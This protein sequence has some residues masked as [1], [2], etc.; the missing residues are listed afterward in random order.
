M[1]IRHHD[2]HYEVTILND[3]KT[4]WYS[5]W[6]D[7]WMIIRHHDTHNEVTVYSPLTKN[8]QYLKWQ[9]ALKVHK[10]MSFLRKFIPIENH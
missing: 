9:A 3:N 1:I 8:N 4:L 10:D 7:Y 2:T 5:L 6:G